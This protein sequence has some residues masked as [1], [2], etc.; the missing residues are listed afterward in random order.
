MKFSSNDAC[1]YPFLYEDQKIV[2]YEIITD[3]IASFIGLLRSYVEN[4]KLKRDLE[5]LCTLTW[6]LNGS[7]RGKCCINKATVTALNKKLK[8]Y[9]SKLTC[10]FKNFILPVGSTSACVSEIIRNKFKHAVRTLFYVQK[11]NPGSKVNILIFD[12]LN[13]L[14]NLFYLI[15]LY[16]RQLNKEEPKIF[17]SQSYTNKAK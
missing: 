1:A 17:K 11:N 5:W 10:N 16:I 2:D 4:S 8:N 13:I 7:V 3:E 15:G 12:C 9:K 14:S 6:N